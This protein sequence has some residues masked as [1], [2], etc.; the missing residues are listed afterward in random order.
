MSS[1]ALLQNLMWQIFFGGFLII[2]EISGSNN[3]GIIASDAARYNY[4]YLKCDGKRRSIF[5]LFARKELILNKNYYHHL[6][7]HLF[8]HQL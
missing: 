7:H 8:Q 6:F 2:L 4:L 3:L 5:K 1:M